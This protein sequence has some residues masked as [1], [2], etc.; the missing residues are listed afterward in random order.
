[1]EAESVFNTLAHGVFHFYQFAQTLPKEDF[2]H[3]IQKA[4][5]ER[6]SEQ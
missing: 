6:W 1:M 4:I 3:V 5:E 2:D